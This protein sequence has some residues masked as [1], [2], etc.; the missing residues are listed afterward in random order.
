VLSLFD[1]K[2][3]IDLAVMKPGQPL[4]T[5]TGRLL[6]GI[7]PAIEH[8]RPDAVLVQGDSTTCFAGALAAGYAKVPVIHLEAGL[9]SYRPLEPFP[10]EMNR[11][12]VA[13]LA[14]LHLAP[15][16]NAA[17]NLM[18]EGVSPSRIEITGN[19]V[20]DALRWVIKN[21]TP[22]DPEPWAEAKM[23]AR[24]LILV[25]THRRENQGYLLRRALSAVRRVLEAYPDVATVFPLHPNPRVRGVV[26]EVLR[27]APRFFPLPP[28]RYE[29]FV[30]LMKQSAI[31]LTDSSSIQ[32]EAP[33]LGRPVLVMRETTERLESLDSGA[34]EM[35]GTSPERIE[36]SMRRLLDDP[37][38]YQVMSMATNVF[39]GGRAAVRVIE[40]INRHWRHM[41][42]AEN[43]EEQAYDLGV[44][45]P[46]R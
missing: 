5:L 2:P 10:E 32:E 45:L 3:M 22:Q 19:T 36:A 33:A 43:A 31:I 25:T 24:R 7:T 12:M 17:D 15:T 20:I 35:V 27:G 9:R 8:V 39:A 29:L 44:D 18:R 28:L 23:A 30:H 1:L 11:R 13:V 16:R 6:E 37:V 21:I 14:S 46:T 40:S 34:V 38:A 42:Q 26:H 41:A 4:D